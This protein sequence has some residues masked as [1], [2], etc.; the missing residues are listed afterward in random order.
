MQEVYS[1]DPDTDATAHSSTRSS[2]SGNVSVSNYGSSSAPAS[3]RRLLSGGKVK[4][5]GEGCVSDSP[6]AVAIKAFVAQHLLSLKEGPVGPHSVTGPQ[7][8]LLIAKRC[9]QS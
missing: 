3:A 2:N 4:V 6:E 5:T 8:G 9:A 7:M 1:V